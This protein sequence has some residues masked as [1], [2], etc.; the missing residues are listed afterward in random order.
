MRIHPTAIISPEARLAADVRVS[1]HAIIDGKI[2]IGAGTSIG[3]NAIIQGRVSIGV[4]NKIGPGVIIGTDPQDLHFDPATD[5]GVWIGDD[6]TLREYVTIHRA[7]AAGKDTSLGHRNF[8]MVGVHLGH[9]VHVGSANILANN[10]LLG[11]HVVFGNQIVA[12]GGSVFHQSIRVG[13]GATTQG[14]SG[15]SMDLPPFTVGAGIN[16]IHGLNV[17]GLRRSGRTPAERAEVK[18]AFELYYRSG[19]NATQALERASGQSWGAAARVF[20]DFL[21]AESKRGVCGRSARRK[22][23]TAERD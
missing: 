6:N 17:I 11:G 19:L 16:L 8:L 4:R 2:E 12:G 23:D 18:R 10:A 7:T 20:L 5:S 21:A 9:D 14:N 13:D 22:S 1:S 15:F 3:P